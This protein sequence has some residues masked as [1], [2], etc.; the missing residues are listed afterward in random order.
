MN[1][2]KTCENCNDFGISEFC[3]TCTC[4]SVGGVIG[5]PTNWE[6]KP[7]DKP[8]ICNILGVAV[9]ERFTIHGIDATFWIEPDGTFSTTPKNA[10]GSTHALLHALETP[11]L[12]LRYP[13]LEED[14]L[15]LCRQ[16]YHGGARWLARGKHLRWY[17]KKPFLRESDGKWDMAGDWKAHSG[18]LPYDL[19]PSI[20]VKQ[21][22]SLDGLLKTSDAKGT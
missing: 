14:E 12:V 19:L 6:P 3:E 9:G 17:S 22:I 21:S 18:K 1:Q 20:K 8:T 2:A 15:A 13:V 10:A 16:L 5:S 4:T 11:S 7:K